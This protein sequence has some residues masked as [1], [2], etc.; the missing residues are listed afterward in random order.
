MDENFPNLKKETETHVQEVH[1]FPINMNPNSPE[2][3]HIK[4]TMSE[5]KENSKC[6]R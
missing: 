3:R 4:I 1:S 6:S 5:V 2:L